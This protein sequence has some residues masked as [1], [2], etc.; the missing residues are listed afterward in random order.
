MGLPVKTM[1]SV[2]SCNHKSG[3]VVTGAQDNTTLPA[4]AEYFHL[5]A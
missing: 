3:T 4:D 5:V 1:T 2:Q